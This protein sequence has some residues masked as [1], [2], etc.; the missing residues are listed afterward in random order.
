MTIFLS[1]AGLVYTFF[2]AIFFFRKDKIK[3]IELKIYKSIILVTL[4]SLVSELLIP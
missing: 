1:I 2:L 3:S 4:A